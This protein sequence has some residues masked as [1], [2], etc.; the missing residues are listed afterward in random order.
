[1]LRAANQAIRLHRTAGAPFEELLDALL[2]ADIAGEQGDTLATH[3]YLASAREL[4]AGL[5]VR[6]AR[7]AV[8]L[9]EARINERAGH[10]DEVLAGLHAAWPDLTTGGYEAEWQAWDLRAGAELRL[11]R[12][13][14]A[15]ESAQ[16]AVSAIE[17][18]RSGLPAG[19]LRTGFLATRARAYGRLVEILLRLNRADRAFEVADAMRG[20]ALLDHLRGPD[21]VLARIEALEEQLSRKEQQGNDSMDAGWRE[22]RRQLE[23]ALKRAR[24]EGAGRTPGRPTGPGDAI[25]G[26]V[27][28]QARQVRMALAEDEALLA[29]FVGQERSHVFV[30]RRDGLRALDLPVSVQAL[31]A[32][33]RLA[34]DSVGQ[35][36]AAPADQVLEALHDQLIA[37]IRAAGL[38]RG[39]RRLV[40][41][42]QGVLAYLPFAAVR[43]PA[44]GRFL[45]QDF[46]LSV[47]SSA[48]ALPGLIRVPA[49]SSAHAGG[50]GF[51]PTPRELPASRGEVEAFRSAVP[52]ATIRIGPAAT[53]AVVRRALEAVSIVHIA[54]HGIMNPINPLYSRVELA[55]GTVTLPSDDGALQVHE[56]LDLQIR[57]RLVFLSGCETGLGQTWATSYRTGEDYATLGQALLYAGATGVVATLWRID[58]RAAGVLAERFY[59]YLRSAPAADA[60]ARAQRDLLDDPAFSAPYFWAGHELIGVAGATGPGS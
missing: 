25:L 51:A 23:G 56:L 27:P 52:G 22:A 21:P 1:A 58:D 5:N 24:E 39:V 30:L 53:E 43:N 45:I 17:R 3:R 16:H 10:A 8:A 18:V 36:N 47:L 33:V 20:R 49:S 55:P 7:V 28:T 11:G 50:E 34:R 4:A 15:A 48:A 19:A 37:P 42:P 41:V 12:L 9:A 46:T 60:L 44:D 2:L 38:L 29:Y 40:L 57:S 26:L 31:T 54:S 14:D 59:R 35:R 13:N 6:T 32:K